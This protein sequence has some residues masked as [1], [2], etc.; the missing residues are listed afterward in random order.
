MEYN[1]KTL[2]RPPSSHSLI[3]SDIISY[4]KVLSSIPIYFNL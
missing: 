3:T 1:P 4:P 2:P